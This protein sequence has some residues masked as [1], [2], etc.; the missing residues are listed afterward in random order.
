MII[1]DDPHKPKK[2][3]SDTARAR[4]LD[5]HDGTLGFRFNDPKTGVEVVVMQRLH[6]RDLSGHLLERGGYTHLCLPARYE[7]PP[8]VPSGPTTPAQQ[9]G[10]LLWPAHIPEPELDGIE[11]T[12][13]S[14]RAA[15][16]LQQ[17]PAAAEG[18]LLKRPW[19]QFFTPEYCSTDD[20]ISQ[21]PRFEQIVASWDTAF[22][23]KTSQRL[24]RRPGLGHPR[25]RPLPALQLPPAREPERDQGR[26][27]GRPRL[28]RAPL[29]A[30]PRTRS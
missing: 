7:R 24:R 30:T 13:G 19:W 20:Q 27:A 28:G 26:D 2:R 29:A 15:G 16:Q 18:E 4:V 8:P 10:E 1:I 3:M 6:E 11:Q 25:R 22:E 17:R 23:D 12:M 21:L 14:F 9:E 5:W